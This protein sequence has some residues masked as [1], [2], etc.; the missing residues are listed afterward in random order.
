MGRSQRMR[1]ADERLKGAPQFVIS[2]PI[3]EI[4]KD[5][6]RAMPALLEDFGNFASTVPTREDLMSA[7]LFVNMALR[8]RIKDAMRA[9]GYSEHQAGRIVNLMVGAPAEGYAKA[10]HNKS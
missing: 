4:G 6:P 1:E 3:S 10:A 9:E 2:T 8:N 7:S 5:D